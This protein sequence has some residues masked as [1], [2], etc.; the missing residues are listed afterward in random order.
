[1]YLARGYAEMELADNYCNGT[2]LS[3]GTTGVPS[4]SLSNVAVYTKALATIDS[5]RA[6]V[7][8]LTDANSVNILNALNILKARVYV[9]LGDLTSAVAL[10]AGI[11]TTYTYD[12][13]Y[14]A[15]SNNILWSQATS[16]RRYNI[17]DTTVISAGTVY[18]V[19]P[20]LPF[21]TSKDPRV[22]TITATGTL[23]QDGAVVSRT[24]NLWTMTSS[25]PLVNGIDARLIEAEAFLKNGDVANWLVTLNA[26][27]ATTLPLSGNGGLTYTSGTLPPLV[28]PGAGATSPQGTAIPARL[29]L[30]FYEKAMWTFG[31]GE[32]LNDMRRLIRQYTIPVTAVFP[33]GSHYRGPPYGPDVNMPIPFNE[34]VNPLYH[35][36]TD[37]NA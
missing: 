13:T 37:R 21:A 26:L 16:Q 32:R 25:T 22:G 14:S 34:Q 20:A 8:G 29:Y 31:R 4:G 33:Q 27:R 18:R 9:S 2:P 36:C 11:A 1:L 28:D 6:L 19:F 5:G 23:S 10:T 30:Q 17:G 24:T 3:D 12:I 7:T 15:Q 35:G